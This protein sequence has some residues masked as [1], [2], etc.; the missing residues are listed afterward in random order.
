[1]PLRHAWF[2]GQACCC[3]CP[4]GSMQRWCLHV[5]GWRAV[6]QPV[7]CGLSSA[8]CVLGGD[9]GATCPTVKVCGIADLALHLSAL[10]HRHLPQWRSTFSSGHLSQQRHDCVMLVIVRACAGMLRTL[11]PWRPSK[12]SSGGCRGRL[13]PWGDPHPQRTWPELPEC[14]SVLGLSCPPRCQ[15]ICC[16]V[17]SASVLGLLWSP[18]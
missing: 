17:E 7:R 12:P 9:W 5:C 13:G 18:R 4:L 16:A 1:M 11:W 2:L 15:T 8:C 6:L 10:L 3:G 14:A